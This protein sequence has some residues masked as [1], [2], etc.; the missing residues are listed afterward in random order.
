MFSASP[1]SVWTTRSSRS[2][3]TV[4]SRSSWCRGRRR[5][6]SCSPLGKSSN[7]ALWP[8]SPRSRGSVPVRHRHSWSS[9]GRGGRHLAHADRAI[10]GRARRQLRPLHPDHRARTARGHYAPGR[11]RDPACRRR[12][13]RHSAGIPASQRYRGMGA[14]DDG[15]RFRRRRVPRLPRGDSRRRG[16]RPVAQYRSTRSRHRRDTAR[17]VAWQLLQFVWLDPAPGAVAPDGL[18]WWPTTSSS[19]VFRGESWCP[20]S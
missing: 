16:R 12:P 3:A 17:S 6:A 7:S 8:D 13:A 10:H 5:A 15:T 20:T 19:T 11:G 14:L 9:T 4:S 1:R 18:S 2:A